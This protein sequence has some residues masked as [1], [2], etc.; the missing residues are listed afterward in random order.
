MQ[1]EK[2]YFQGLNADDDVNLL[3]E[4]DYINAENFRIGTTDVGSAL[5]L[6]SVGGTTPIESLPSAP[7]RNH[8][9]LCAVEDEE[10]RRIIYFLFYEDGN[11][12]LIKCY[13]RRDGLV[14][15]V[16]DQTQ[17]DLNFSKNSLIQAKVYGD[18][19]IYTDDNQEIKII[20]IEAG[21][22]ANHPSYVTDVLPYIIPTGITPT[23]PRLAH[24]DITLL[25]RPPIYAPLTVKELD[26]T[27][28]INGIK[29]QAFQFA[30]RYF[31]R[32]YQYSVLGIYSKLENYNAKDLTP[33]TPDDLKKIKVTMSLDE[34]IPQTV[35]RVELLV[36][37][38]D[39]L[40]VQAIQVWDKSDPDQEALITNHNTAAI[41]L[42]TWFFNDKTGISVSSEEFSKPEENIPRKCKTLDTARKRLFLANYLEGF[43]TPTKSSLTLTLIDANL[44]STITGVKVFLWH[45]SYVNFPAAAD[46]FSS[47]YMVYLDTVANVGWY[48]L[49]G[50]V[51]GSSQWPVLGAVPTTISYSA[52]QFAGTTEAAA[53]GFNIPAGYDGY[54]FYNYTDTTSTATV[55]DLV[56]G[57]HAKLFKTN[58]SIQLGIGFYDRLRR[59]IG[60]FTDNRTNTLAQPNGG[61]MI[62]PDRKFTGTVFQSAIRWNLI[63]GAV[64]AEIPAEAYYYGLVMTKNLRTRYFVQTYVDDCRYATKNPQDGTVTI[65]NTS[66]S[67]SGK[68]YV[69]IDLGS[70][71]KDG[72]GWEISPGDIARVYY[73][74]MVNYPP[75][76][77]SVV[78]MQGKHIL[79]EWYDFGTFAP[80]SKMIVELF[81]PYK[82]SDQEDFFEIGEMYKVN[83]PG[84]AT[85]SY[86]TLTGT[87]Q[88]DTH[89]LERASGATIPATY[90]AESMSTNDKFWQRWHDDTGKVF[91]NIQG[92]EIRKP[93]SIAFSNVFVIGTQT[94]GLSSFEIL[95]TEDVSPESGAIQKLLL[96]SKVQD[97]GTVMLVICWAETMT[98][99]LGEAQISDA[100]STAFFVKSE[101]V[102]GS[103]NALRGSYGTQN[104]ESVVLH[105][106]Q[107]YWFDAANGCFVRYDVNG[108]FPISDYKMKRVAKLIGETYM[109]LT[110]ADI[111]TLGN[112]P[113]IFGGVDPH[114][115]EVLWAIPKLGVPPKGYLNDYPLSYVDAIGQVTITNVGDNGDKIEVFVVDPLYGKLSLG[116]YVKQAT[117]TDVT[118][119]ATSVKNVLALNNYG[120]V[121]T[122]TAGVISI[123]ARPN[124]GEIM[125]IGSRLSVQI[126]P[127][128]VVVVTWR[129]V[130]PVCV[131]DG[132]GDNTGMK[133]YVSRERVLDSVPSGYT[134]LN[135]PGSDF[136][137]NAP[138]T[139][140]CPL[141]PPAATNFLLIN[142]TEKV[143]VN[144]VDKIKI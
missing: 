65:D 13:D 87:I 90:F 10:R 7:G 122:N 85:R 76:N 107:A 114:H 82:R 18:L 109:S 101:G 95:D 12:N 108:L 77:L 21:I 96:T 98:M 37:N 11:G 14:Y 106:G 59:R 40:A 56:I 36:K 15:Q 5:R 117:D 143:L 23:N 133:R 144:S 139:T 142:T 17:A 52:L 127:I 31:Y 61:V 81:I 130:N 92:K 25:R 115:N 73:S 22:K 104:A 129:G 35:H 54:S 99:Y 126:T 124:L 140:L 27:Y 97:D 116:Y 24:E 19:L 50:A 71:L 49:P 89:L 68:T 46:K 84:T 118:I 28:P 123:K 135:T 119:L 70:L 53:A 112:R 79:C 47:S 128:S 45:C 69:A 72:M 100:A 93:Y 32:D 60:M 2:K 34:K 1:L 3:A 103:I 38:M 6:E 42:V 83:T 63:G 66:L 136:V 105:R 55:T 4:T 74:D 16:L 138:D 94:N 44:T 110:Q 43:N 102:I 137:P 132:S 48:Q 131:K 9:P 58:S 125:N 86:N 88:G 134:E 8:V 75:V 26:T 141:P 33:T 120:Y 80:T 30:W 64:P 113:F 78:G 20:N 91:P 121:V 62:I 39:T 41:P 29:E 111:E 51:V 57:D 67:A